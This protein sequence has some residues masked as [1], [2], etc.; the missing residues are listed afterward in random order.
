MLD[1]GTAGRGNHDRV[2]VALTG[3][4]WLVLGESF[5]RGWRAYCDGRSL[6]APVVLDG[7]ANGW[8][9]PAS[10]H[11]V[12]FAFAPQRVVLIG[13]LLSALACLALLAILLLRRPAG[14]AAGTPR[15]LDLAAAVQG[16]APRRAVAIGLVAAG[17]L[18]FVF[19]ARAGVVIGPVVALILWRGF[20]A[21]LPAIVA[22]A[23]LAV[24][25]P[26]LYTIFTPTDHG[27][28]NF[29]YPVDLIGA[30]W[31]AVGAVLMLGLSLWA[32]LA[33]AIRSARRARAPVAP[34]AAGPAGDADG[35]P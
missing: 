29:N 22:G 19:A 13:Y 9:A 17:A 24:V 15:D 26:L 12:H 1:P 8:R 16:M 4:S 32:T 7:F 18:G 21:R 30:H 25:L 35:G 14:A 2:R 3:P 11:S 20:P 34:A 6:G 31:V 28:Y 10:C 33:S 5:D 27:G 23:V